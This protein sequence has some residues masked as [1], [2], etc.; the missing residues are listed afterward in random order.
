MSNR[1]VVIVFGNWNYLDTKLHHYMKE[2][3]EIRLIKPQITNY[4]L[5]TKQTSL[6]GAIKQFITNTYMQRLGYDNH[7][8]HD[9]EPVYITQSDFGMTKVIIL[10][11]FIFLTIIILKFCCNFRTEPTW[12]YPETENTE[13]FTLES[14]E[15]VEQ[16]ENQYEEREETTL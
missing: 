13:T 7:T 11:I 3:F 9:N 15:N 10:V 12:H 16:R 14:D 8:K 2:A 6:K 1:G 4:I 5:H